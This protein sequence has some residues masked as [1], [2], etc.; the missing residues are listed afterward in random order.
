M[1]LF[2]VCLACYNENRTT[3]QWFDLSE[4]SDVSELESEVKK[5]PKVC[6]Q[7]YKN[8]EEIAIHDFEGF[9]KNMGE[10]TSIETV[11]EYLDV[12][13]EIGD[14]DATKAL[15]EYL[16]FDDFLKY[17]TG[18]TY[19]GEFSLGD[20]AFEQFMGCEEKGTRDFIE[21]F[22]R[23]INF[24]SMEKELFHNDGVL[25]LDSDIHGKQHVFSPNY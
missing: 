9:P 17:G 1:K 21:K 3:G 7:K 5:H 14:E 13:N 8:H 2:V 15:A 19:I 24:E 10:Y 4:Y 11:F 6:V 25:F 18:Y 12:M 22:V 20:Y 16:G 23:Y